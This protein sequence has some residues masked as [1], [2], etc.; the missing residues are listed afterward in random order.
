MDWSEQLSASDG[1]DH[2]D[3]SLLSVKENKFYADL[4]GTTTTQQRIRIHPELNA[5]AIDRAK[6]LVRVDAHLRSTR[7]T[8]LGVPRGRRLG[9]AAANSPR[10]PNGSARR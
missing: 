9:L 6:R 3:V 1:V 7:R 2:V 10:F 5:I 4:S 8:G